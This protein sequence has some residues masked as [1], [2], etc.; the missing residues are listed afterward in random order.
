[1][2]DVTLSLE[3]ASVIAADR[4]KEDQRGSVQIAARYSIL[5]L[6]GSLVSFWGEQRH[7]N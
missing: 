2:S 5:C 1:M 6:C 4:R 7:L 3:P